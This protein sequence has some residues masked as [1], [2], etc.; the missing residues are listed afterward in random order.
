MEP[1]MREERSAK[2][3]AADGGELPHVEADQPTAALAGEG[4]L[5]GSVPATETQ[6]PAPAKISKAAA[7]ALARTANAHALVPGGVGGIDSFEPG[8]RP[9]LKDLVG[10]LKNRVGEEKYRELMKSKKETR[11]I[12]GN[13]LMATPIAAA[14]AV[15]AAG[16]A[17]GAGD[18][19]PVI[20]TPAAPKQR[21]WKHG[22]CLARMANYIQEYPQLFVK[23]DEQLSRSQKDDGAKLHAGMYWDQMSI[24]FNL[25]PNELLD[26]NLH[27][28]IAE[29][30]TIDPSAHDYEAT[31]SK[32]DTEFRDARAKL[33]RAL[34]GFRKSG[35]GDGGPVKEDDAYTYSAKF[36]DFLDG[37]AG[38][39]YLYACLTKGGTNLLECATSHLASAAQRDSTEQPKLISQRKRNAGGGGSGGGGS[40]LTSPAI[41]TTITVRHERPGDEYRSR[42]AAAD[43]FRQEA[44][45]VT[46]IL[47]TVY[48]L[49]DRLKRK[50]DELETARS[51]SDGDPAA[52]EAEISK[53]KKKIRY[54]DD[55]ADEFD[56][57][58]ESVITALGE[59]PRHTHQ[60]DALPIAAAAMAAGAGAA[61]AAMRT[62]G[63]DGEK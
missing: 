57:S 11:K 26:P 23:R 31:G 5:D 22:S 10:E 12:I 43:T 25:V 48:A 41:P 34:A 54:W 33:D 53:L 35:N 17:A 16:A 50:R 8:S 45:A 56:S 15:A 61:E 38:L 52:V 19:V 32:L 20:A 1:T 47:N 30:V 14:A 37:D 13:V 42:A 59:Y 36:K 18:G 60:P 46:T 24:D 27:M 4:T 28:D 58:S 21:R 39:M 44:H 3:T 49:E 9:T 2:K 63:G 6:P 62:A 40:G 29:L 55:K 7:K 51:S